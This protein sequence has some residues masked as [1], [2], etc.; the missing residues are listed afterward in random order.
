MVAVVRLAA[1]LPIGGWLGLA[2]QVAA[3]GLAYVALCLVWWKISGNRHI[4]GIL[5]RSTKSAK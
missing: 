1:L 5:K 3:G 2:A 4:L